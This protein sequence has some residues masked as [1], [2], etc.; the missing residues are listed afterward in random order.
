MA[1]AILSN[2]R[3]EFDTNNSADVAFMREFL[4]VPAATLAIP[5]VELSEP[6]SVEPVKVEK[7]KK[8]NSKT[9]EFECGHHEPV[10]RGR[11]G[12]LC[13]TCSGNGN[14]ASNTVSEPESKPEKPSNNGKSH[15][16]GGSFKEWL[17][18]HGDEPMTKKMERSI[19]YMLT[20]RQISDDDRAEFEQDVNATPRITCQTA[21]DIIETLH[22]SPK[23][24]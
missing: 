18:E 17:A 21:S 6:N 5:T 3:I 23:V 19:R 4:S 11:Y 10:S 7:P 20:N 15:R 8:S 16:K 22:D 14:S 2:A 12:A 13:S 24:A 1:T 9:H